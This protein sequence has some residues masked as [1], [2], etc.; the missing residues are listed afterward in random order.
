VTPA[1]ITELAPDRVRGFLPG[2]GYQC[3]VLI[4]SLMPWFTARI[5]EGRSYAW[6]MSITASSV[7][8]LCA[9]VAWLGPERRGI[10]YGAGV[11]RTT[12]DR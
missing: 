4:A 6:A 3:G 2:F 11:S 10:V 1:H 7:F 12:P 8:V 5:A 9:L